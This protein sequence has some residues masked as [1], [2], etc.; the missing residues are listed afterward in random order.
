MEKTKMSKKKKIVIGV[1]IAAVVILLLLLLRCCSCVEAG[2][3]FGFWSANGDLTARNEVDIEEMKAIMN[4]SNVPVNINATAFCEAGDAPVNWLIENPTGSNKNLL[5]EI[6]LLA[7]GS[8]QSNFNAE[9]D[10]GEKI[11][12]T[13]KLL[14]PG[15]HIECKDAAGTGLAGYDYL[16]RELPPGTYQVIALFHAYS[17]DEQPEY[18]GTAQAFISLTVQG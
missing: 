10:I 8:E 6:Y 9:A 11:Y 18:I 16:D 5:V 13:E 7:E 14:P 3:P 12:S 4:G 15:S 2:E 17:L 1:L